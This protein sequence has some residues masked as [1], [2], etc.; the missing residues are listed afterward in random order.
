M[1]SVGDDGE[2]EGRLQ[3]NG[4]SRP[5]GNLKRPASPAWTSYTE[6]TIAERITDL[7]LYNYTVTIMQSAMTCHRLGG[8]I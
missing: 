8:N 4:A 3:G 6:D 7:Y 1:L 5:A 2:V